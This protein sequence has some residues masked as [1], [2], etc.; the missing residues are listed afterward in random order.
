M[1]KKVVKI[2]VTYEMELE[3][4]PN[5]EYVKAYENEAE[6]LVDCGS[7]RFENVLPVINQGGVVVKDVTMIV[8]GDA[9]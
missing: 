5:N 4:D 7:Y 3:I 9:E 1:A 2:N 8:L 6:M